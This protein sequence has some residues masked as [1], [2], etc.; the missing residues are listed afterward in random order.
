MGTGDNLK[1]VSDCWDRLSRVP[2]S[3]WNTS[4]SIRLP[5]QLS[6]VPSS[7]SWNTSESLRLE[8]VYNSGHGHFQ[9]WPWKHVQLWALNISRSTAGNTGC[10]CVCVRP[11]LSVYIFMHIVDIIQFNFY[12]MTSDKWVRNWTI[13][14]WRGDVNT[15]TYEYLQYVTRSFLNPLKKLKDFNF[16]SSAEFDSAVSVTPWRFCLRV[17]ICAKSKP[18]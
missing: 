5:R 1:T 17:N 12:C 18:Y 16:S 7:S 11:V 2:S 15:A 4:K 10:M 6:R 3:S 13:K 14:W 9:S 8:R